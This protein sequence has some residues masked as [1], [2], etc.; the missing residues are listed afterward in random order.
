MSLVQRFANNDTAMPNII[1]QRSTITLLDFSAL[2]LTSK[3]YFLAL[4]IRHRQV[5]SDKVIVILNKAR[6]SVFRHNTPVK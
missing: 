2:F 5:K 4:F 3:R 6:C 1:L